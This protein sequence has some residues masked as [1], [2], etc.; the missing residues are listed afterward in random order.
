MNKQMSV[1]EAGRKG[2]RARALKLSRDR[3]V[4]IARQGYNASPLSDKRAKSQPNEKITE[5]KVEESS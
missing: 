1:S 3:R 4:E 2:G 5:N